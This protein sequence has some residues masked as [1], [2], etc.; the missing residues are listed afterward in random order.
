MAVSE[1]SVIALFGMA[2]LLLIRVR[3]KTLA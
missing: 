1:P 2:F 3:R